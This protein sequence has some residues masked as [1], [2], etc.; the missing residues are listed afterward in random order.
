MKKKYYYRPRYT[1]TYDANGGSGTMTD[2]NSPYDSGSTVTVLNNSF[3]KTNANFYKWNTVA[4][5]SGTDYDPADTFTITSNVT[6]YA[7]WITYSGNKFGGY[8]D[9]CS[10]GVTFNSL[11]ASTS[12]SRPGYASSVSQSTF[13][14]NNLSDAVNSNDTLWRTSNGTYSITTAF[15]VPDSGEYK[16]RIMEIVGHINQGFP[17]WEQLLGG[18]QQTFTMNGLPAQGGGYVVS[19]TFTGLTKD[20]KVVCLESS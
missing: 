17:V 18:D 19:H 8:D 5:G 4:D 7:Q 6:L 10:E 3:T 13:N 11:T 20:Y 14:Q 12:N 2:S 16:I 9:S 1:V 15:S